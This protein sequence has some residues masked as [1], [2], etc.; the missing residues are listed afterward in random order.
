MLKIGNSV[1]EILLCGQLIKGHME[2][3]NIGW[4]EVDENNVQE[5]YDEI[6]S[7]LKS[8][9]MSIDDGP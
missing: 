3:N 1:F 6:I 5:K 2:K 4:W 8:E 7:Q 9:P